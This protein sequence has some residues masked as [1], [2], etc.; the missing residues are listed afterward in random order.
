MWTYEYGWKYSRGPQQC[1]P[2][3]GYKPPGMGAENQACPLWQQPTLLNTEIF[4]F[5]VIPISSAFKDTGKHSFKE[6]VL[7]NSSQAKVLGS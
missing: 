2:E 7:F 1:I 3:G 4:T 6:T 5:L